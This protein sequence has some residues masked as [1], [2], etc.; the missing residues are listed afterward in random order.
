VNQDMLRDAPSK[1][2]LI[3]HCDLNHGPLDGLKSKL[4]KTYTT[5]FY[6]FDNSKE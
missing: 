5:C 4:L 1:L 3:L 6:I 2:K